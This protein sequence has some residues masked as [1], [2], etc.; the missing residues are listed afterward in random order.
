[1][2]R[3]PKVVTGH[4]ELRLNSAKARGLPPGTVAR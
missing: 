1:V 4:D 2:A 3:Q